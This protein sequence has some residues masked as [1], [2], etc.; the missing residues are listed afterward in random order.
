M[1]PKKSLAKNNTN[2]GSL[3][4]FVLFLYGAGGRTRTGTVSLPT[5]FESVASA[6]F[7]T[8]AHLLEYI[9]TKFWFWQQLKEEFIKKW[10]IF[11]SVRVLFV[12]SDI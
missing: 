11:N 4:W 3:L 2:L 8:P 1:A 10:R 5:D 9:S 6:N 7:T 12:R